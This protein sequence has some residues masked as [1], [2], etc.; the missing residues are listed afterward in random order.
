MLSHW[1][2]ITTLLK[3]TALEHN[4]ELHNHNA[5]STSSQSLYSELSVKGYSYLNNSWWPILN[6][7]NN[8]NVC[9]LLTL[10][11]FFSVLK[12]TECYFLF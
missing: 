3:A 1:S 4:T 12:K 8:R 10:P 6:T 7:A 5:S 2:C 11:F 9:K